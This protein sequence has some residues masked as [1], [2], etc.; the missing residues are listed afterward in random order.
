MKMQAKEAQIT[1]VGGGTKI[2]VVVTAFFVVVT[3][4]FV[5]FTTCFVVLTT[6][7]VVSTTFFDVVRIFLVICWKGKSAFAGHFCA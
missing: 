7:F 6:C 3:T 5:V 1:F 2:L 4:C